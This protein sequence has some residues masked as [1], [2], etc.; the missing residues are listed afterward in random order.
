MKCDQQNIKRQRSNAMQTLIKKANQIKTLDEFEDF[1]IDNVREEWWSMKIV[2]PLIIENLSNE[3]DIKND[4][5]EWERFISL[6]YR[7]THPYTLSAVE[8]LYQFYP[9]YPIECLF[10]LIAYSVGQEYGIVYPLWYEPIIQLHEQYQHKIDKTLFEKYLIF[11]NDSRNYFTALLVQKNFD[12]PT[13][14]IYAN[15]SELLNGRLR[16]GQPYLTLADIENRNLDTL[17]DT[18][19]LVISD[20]NYDGKSY[21]DMDGN[22]ISLMKEELENAICET[23]AYRKMPDNVSIYSVGEL[24]SFND[25]LLYKWGIVKY[26][27]YMNKYGQIQTYKNLYRDFIFSL[28]IKAHSDL[29]LKC[30]ANIKDILLDIYPSLPE[31]I[32]TDTLMNKSFW[33]K[34][35]EFQKIWDAIEKVAAKC[36]DEYPE[37]KPFLGDVGSASIIFQHKKGF[38]LW[39]LLMG[40]AHYN[41]YRAKIELYESMLGV[42][43]YGYCRKGTHALQCAGKILDTYN[44]SYFID[45]WMD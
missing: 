37:E 28:V 24:Y 12:I 9:N 38:A 16:Y 13:N 39:L 36:F 4:L 31:R 40:Y 8:I 5:K 35:E 34:T 26:L 43:E 29:N 14:S 7:Y 20:E 17:Y 32:L 10:E 30:L 22:Y 44:I 2:V 25:F 3:I 21:C 6:L 23:D 1:C 33:K 42:F 11:I 45:V 15:I 41:E 19:H 27:S 18:G